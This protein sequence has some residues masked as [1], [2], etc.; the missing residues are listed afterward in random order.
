MGR[1]VSRDTN[2]VRFV[3]KQAGTDNGGWPSVMVL[4]RPGSTGCLRTNMKAALHPE[5]A[6]IPSSVLVVDLP[7]PH[8]DLLLSPP[9]GC[10][11]DHAGS[12]EEAR[13]RLVL[14][15]YSL[16]LCSQDLPADTRLE[17]LAH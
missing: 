5:S 16:V 12:L 2:Q 1:S 15:Q 6:A 7:P 8:Q 3:V 13:D 14:Q 11:V 17:L 9:R 10:R 4:S